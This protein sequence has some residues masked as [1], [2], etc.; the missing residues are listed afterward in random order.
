M[1]LTAL[2]G[3]GADGGDRSRWVILH[4]TGDGRWDQVLTT[5]TQLGAIWGSG[6]SDVYILAPDAILHHP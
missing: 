4:T 1:F 5:S 2:Q 6:P 3:N